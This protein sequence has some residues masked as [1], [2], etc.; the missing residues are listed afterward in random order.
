MLGPP[1]TLHA[2][3]VCWIVYHHAETPHG[4]DMSAAQIDRFHR[5]ERGFD[6]IGY[7]FVIR[8]SGL[9]EVGRPLTQQGAHTKGLND[10]GV[11]IVFGGNNDTAALTPAQFESAVDLG[12]RLARLYDVSIERVIGHREVN[13]LVD[14]GHLAPEYRTHKSCPGVRV[15]M[16]KIRKA[17]AARLFPPPDVAALQA[18]IDRAA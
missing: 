5:K 10:C 9:V 18:E 6:R 4:Q 13:D 11:G 2:D 14:A 3:Q 12:V 15:S 8:L 16:W 7:H 17:I 1:P